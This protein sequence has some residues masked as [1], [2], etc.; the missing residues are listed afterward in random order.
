MGRILRED[1][2]T[3]AGNGR[4][5]GII[6]PMALSATVF[7][8]DVDLADSDRQV[9][10]QLSLRLARH[11][12]ESDEFLV[13]RLLA[14]CLEYTEGIEFSRGLSDA[15]DPPIAV[16]DLTGRLRAWIDVG[17][18][19]AERLHRAGKAADRVVVYVHKEHRQWLR[20]LEGAVI[21]R[22]DGL[23]IQ[24]FDPAFVAAFVARLERR[25]SFALSVAEGDLFVAFADGTI[26][27]RLRRVVC[28]PT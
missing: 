16:C 7:A 13:A 15:D 24:A 21:H 6:V 27:G 17:T 10:E 1:S 12:S 2:I 8:F 4:I 26:T 20:Q 14:Y 11:P 5:S 18:P 22:R 3:V 19:A 23:V 9:Y 28:P 25:M